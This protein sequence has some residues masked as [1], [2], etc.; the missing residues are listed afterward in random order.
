M[1]PHFK[2]KACVSTSFIGV[3]L[4]WSDRNPSGVAHLIFDSNGPVLVATNH[5]TSDK[6]LISWITD[7]CGDITWVGIDAPIIAPNPPKTSRAADKIVTSL[8]GR[9][10]AGVYPGNRKRCARPIR[11]CKKLAA[12]GFSPDPFFPSRSGRRQLEIFP[13]LAQI[14]L[15][16]RK[17]I[18][19]Y[20]KGNVEQKRRGLRTLQQ[21]IAHFLPRANPPLLSSPQLLELVSE[22]PTT[23]RGRRLKGLEDRLDALLCAYMTLY[24]WAW[25]E[26]KCAVFGDLKSGYII[27]PKYSPQ[28]SAISS[29]RKPEAES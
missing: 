21:T 18:I 11:L 24:F 7:H 15:F 16:G 1:K 29:Q 27:G 25:G 20:K 2:S 3:D 26:E 9:F 14:A 5:L 6:D 28:R 22:N 4:A 19:K 23:L 10:H 8:F 13:H 17:R 12:I